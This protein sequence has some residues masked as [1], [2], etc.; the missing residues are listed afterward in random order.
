[1]FILRVTEPAVQNPPAGIPAE[2]PCGSNGSR[3]G[4]LHRRIRLNM[5]VLHSRIAV[6]V[7]VIGIAAGQYGLARADKYAGDFMS[8][9]GG[10]RALGMGGAFA[11]VADDASALYWNPAGISGFEKRQ[12]LFMHAEQFGDLL[13]YNFAAFVAPV[14]S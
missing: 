8:I 13:D 2:R 5:R 9:G 11:A 4:R 12:A 14:S 6:F 3:Y 1:M 10:A 7:C